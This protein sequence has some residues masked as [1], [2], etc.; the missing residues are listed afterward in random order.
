MLFSRYKTSKYSIYRWSTYQSNALIFHCGKKKKDCDQNFWKFCGKKN[1]GNFIFWNLRHFH[2]HQ[3]SK[4]NISFVFF[5]HK[6]CK[7]YAKNLFFFMPKWKIRAFDW[8]VHHIWIIWSF[9]TWKSGKI[10]FPQSAKKCSLSPLLNFPSLIMI[11]PKKMTFFAN[12]RHCAD[13]TL[14]LCLMQECSTDGVHL[15]PR[16]DLFLK[17]QKKTIP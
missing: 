2:K 15:Q 17:K 7:K 16:L 8:W 4:S 12:Q 3:M 11:H 14:L 5:A 9:V 6:I 1:K 13:K 10:F